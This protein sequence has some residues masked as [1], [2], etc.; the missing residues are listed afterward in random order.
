MSD[1]LEVSKRLDELTKRVDDIRTMLDAWIEEQTSKS[2]KRDKLV[3]AIIEKT[4]AGAVWA[5]LAY[6]VGAGWDRLT[7]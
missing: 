2:N 3:D 7:K 5:L 6:I 4:L 1:V